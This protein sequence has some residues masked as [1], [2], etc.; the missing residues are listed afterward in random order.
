MWEKPKKKKDKQINLN[1]KMDL[2]I[3]LPLIFSG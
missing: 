1:K 3:T 2:K